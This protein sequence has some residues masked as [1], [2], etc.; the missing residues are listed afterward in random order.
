M[1][2]RRPEQG[3]GWR[4]PAPVFDPE[5]VPLDPAFLDP[6]VRG[7]AVLPGRLTAQALRAHFANPPVWQPETSFDVRESA[8]QGR[9]AQP[10]DAAVLVPLLVRSNGVQVLLTQRTAHLR[11]HAG[12]ISF[13]GGRVERGDEDAI[14]A[15]LRESGEE[16]GLN[17]AAVEVMG[18]LPQYL[19][20][21]GYRVTP[22]VGLIE[23]SPS[24]AIDVSEVE[25]A[26][27]VPLA[28]VMD[29]M[30]HERRVLDWA[31]GQHHF[32]AIPYTSDRRY[33]IWGATAAMLR[34]LY[35][36]LSAR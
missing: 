20:V 16:V 36:F 25:R 18:V 15:A 6:K 34:N 9:G 24:L 21:T 33:F 8:E 22:V 2:D 1:S 30:H 12:Q 27:E 32:F 17:P 3:V 10:L 29:P 35:R 7:Q 13:P 5:T 19:T 28:F 26:F 11:D 31:G 14:A 23:V 4:R